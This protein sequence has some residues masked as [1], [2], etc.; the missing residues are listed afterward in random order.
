[1]DNKDFFS[2]E[3]IGS[4]IIDKQSKEVF[5]FIDLLCDTYAILK[6]ER[7]KI[8]LQFT[9]K[10]HSEDWCFISEGFFRLKNSTGEPLKLN[11]INL[12]T[13][14][15]KDKETFIILNKEIKSIEVKK[16]FNEEHSE[17]EDIK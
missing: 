8:K 16:C 15:L 1:M 14:I 5:V 11:F 4:E 17:M 7:C 13:S 9:E 10:N 6:N 12:T 3:K 2:I